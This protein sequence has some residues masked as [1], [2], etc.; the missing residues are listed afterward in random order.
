MEG[1]CAAPAPGKASAQLPCHGRRVQRSHAMK[2]KCVAPSHG[3]R[4]RRS[5][6][7]EG[8]CAAPLPQKVSTDIPC[9][10]SRQQDLEDRGCVPRDVHASRPSCRA[11]ER[12][13]NIK[14][15]I[16]AAGNAETPTPAPLLRTV[17]L[18]QPRSPPHQ[19]R[20]AVEGTG[21]KRLTVLAHDHKQGGQQGTEKIIR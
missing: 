6:A 18:Q 15:F 5:L 16:P 8:E 2:G 19:A 14:I 20:Q 11:I 4:V 17:S 7:T 12:K 9:H 21:R 10:K 3:R 13:G 1:K